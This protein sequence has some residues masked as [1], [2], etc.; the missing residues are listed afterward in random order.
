M[1]KKNL[2]NRQKTFLTKWIR[3][4]SDKAAR[5]EREAEKQSRW[6]LSVMFGYKPMFKALWLTESHYLPTDR[7]WK[8]GE[9]GVAD[10]P[11]LL[12]EHIG[13]SSRRSVKNPEQQAAC[14]SL[15][16]QTRKSSTLM[17][18]TVHQLSQTPE[19]CRGKYKH[20]LGLGETP[21]SH[22]LKVRVGRFCSFNK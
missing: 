2:L 21:F 9:A 15:G 16:E 4:K 3:P 5:H 1:N 13:G 11:K 17:W 10:L 19:R 7:S 12:W 8:S 20:L 18:R 6:H 14:V 22:R